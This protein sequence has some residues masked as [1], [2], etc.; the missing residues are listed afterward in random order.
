MAATSDRFDV[1]ALPESLEGQTTALWWIGLGFYGVGDTLTTLIGYWAGRG[2]EV[3]PVVSVLM[4]EFGVPALFAVKVA[5][6]GGFF[7]AW[8]VVQSPG[9]VGIPLALSVVGIAVT[10]WNGVVLLTGGPG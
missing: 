8:R 10:G 4:A 7:L 1:D 2:V 3:G 6:I 9:R 5:V